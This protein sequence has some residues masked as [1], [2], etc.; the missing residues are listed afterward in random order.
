MC[1]EEEKERN[2]R[3]DF[4][5]GNRGRNY[6]RRNFGDGNYQRRNFGDFSEQDDGD[7]RERRRHV[8]L[9]ED[10]ILC[11]R[12]RHESDMV[13]DEIMCKLTELLTHVGEKV[14]KIIFW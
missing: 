12:K 3:S 13:E 6:Q 8:G 14:C 4:G 1:D 7:Q 5:I 11:K 9:E 10:D 2:G